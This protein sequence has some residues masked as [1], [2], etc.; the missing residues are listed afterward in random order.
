MTNQIT[1][2]NLQA[3]VNDINRILADDFNVDIDASI[4][5]ANGGWSL[6]GDKESRNISRT[7]HMPKRELYNQMTTILEILYEVSRQQRKVT[8]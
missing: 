5:G 1:R 2:A 8:A 7:G 4:S 3:R 6:V